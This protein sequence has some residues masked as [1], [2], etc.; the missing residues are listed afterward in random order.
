MQ[1]ALAAF[2]EEMA[3][4]IIPAVYGGPNDLHLYDSK[5]ELDLRQLVQRLNGQG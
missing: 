1:D 3:E 4:D 5:P 2:R